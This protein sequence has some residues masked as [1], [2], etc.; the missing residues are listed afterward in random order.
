MDYEQ[1]KYD[2]RE[3][4]ES[5]LDMWKRRALAAESDLAALSQ[6]CTGE[7]TKQEMEAAELVYHHRSAHSAPGEIRK[8]CAKIIV[9]HTRAHGQD[10]FTLAA[11]VKELEALHEH[12]TEMLVR[13]KRGDCP[14]TAKE[15]DKRGGF[16]VS[17]FRRGYYL[18]VATFIRAHD[19]KQVAEDV[20]KAYGAIDFTG[21]DEYDL[22]VLRPLA[23][24]IARKR[25]SFLDSPK[26]GTKG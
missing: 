16:G 22:E 20:L 3:S 13:N 15:K 10:A 24:E 21:I 23:D 18:A 19:Q 5:E 12:L 14:S 17:E 1:L 8:E 6:P 25:A 9:E 4:L 7:P 2:Q 11:K 26:P